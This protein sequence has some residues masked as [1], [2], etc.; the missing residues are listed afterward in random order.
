[1]DSRSPTL[2]G[3][4]TIFRRPALGFAEISWRWA[5]GAA[6][7]LLIVFSLL[8]YLRTLPVSQL[9]L[10]LL[11]TRQPALVGQALTTIFHGSGPRLVHASIV[12]FLALASVWIMVAAL[13]R[14]LTLRAISSYFEGREIA[15]TETKTWGF[16]SLLGLNFFRV[17]AVL[18]AMVGCFAAILLGRA[19]SA[20]DRSFAAITFLAVLAVLL[21]VWLAWSVVNWFLSL[22]SVFAVI[23]GEG[24]FGSMA[25]AIRL[26]R[27]PTA[28]VF[29]VGAWFGMAHI[30]AFFL[31]SSA[32]AFPLGF[33]TV[34]PPAVVIGGVFVVTLLYLAAADFLYAGRLAAYVAIIEF[35]AALAPAP[36]PSVQPPPDFSRTRNM[37]DQNEPILSDVPVS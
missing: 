29:A 28:P 30:V 16:R 3:F 6:S 11:K 34:L 9:D 21:L 8:E 14:D 2:E 17:A 7:A 22:A 19:A 4:R 20:Q 35:P 23:A 27:N 37:V 36:S 12:L 5:F 32:V 15:P 25:A 18:A 24:T 33:A 26:C 10:L 13:S 31:A 1:M